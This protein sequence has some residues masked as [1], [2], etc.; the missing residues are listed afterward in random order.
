MDTWCDDIL[1]EIDLVSTLGFPGRIIV[2]GKQACPILTGQNEDDVIMA[3]CELGKGR[4][5]VFAHSGYGNQLSDLNGSFENSALYRNVRNWLTRKELS[6]KANILNLD[7]CQNVK[8]AK[9]LETYDLLMST[10]IKES[11]TCQMVEEYIKK[12]GAFVHAATPWGYMQFNPGKKPYEMAYMNI[13][14]EVGISY[15]KELSK[16]HGPGYA[17]ELSKA[18]DA[19]LSRY[20]SEEIGKLTDKVDLFRQLKEL[21][22]KYSS[23]FRQMID[24]HWKVLTDNVTRI[25]SSGQIKSN[26]AK[27]KK[28]LDFWLLAVD[29]L[30]KKNFKAPGVK[31]FPGDF[32][33]LPDLTKKDVKFSSTFEDF[34][35]TSCYVPAGTEANVTVS[36]VTNRWTVI[37]G[38]HS[39]C[40]NMER[41][42]RWPKITIETE[43]DKAGRYDISSPFGGSV[44]F[45]SPKQNSSYIEASINDIVT[46]PRFDLVTKGKPWKESRNDSGL[47][48]DISGKYVTVTLPSSSIRNVDDPT[49]IMELYDHLLK[50]YHDLRG[51]NIDKERK[52]WIV[53]DIQ[54]THYMHAG[55]PIVTHLDVADPSKVCFLLNGKSFKSADFWGIYHEIGHNMQQSE[56]TFDGTLEVTVNI[57][58]LYGMYVICGIDP[59]THSWLMRQTKGALHYLKT[60]ADFSKWK[61]EAGMALYTYAQLIHSFKWDAYKRVFRRYQVLNPS[62]KPKSDQDKI[63]L[64]FLI[65][66][67]ETKLNLA[68][69]GIF[70]G[71]PF[72]EG[73]LKK[74]AALNFKP[75]LPEDE[76]TKEVPDRVKFVKSRFPALVQK[77]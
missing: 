53:T 52:M 22:P 65:F 68:P 10:G 72:S 37:V 21:P 58:T 49:Q 70:W 4:I 48:A 30:G 59:W 39:D 45:L 2:F 43:I 36:K 6:N 38:A 19:N 46:C 23:P 44:Y 71:L 67:E 11:V 14:L 54:T 75:F 76:I 63:D 42:N 69:V 7:S 77:V 47:W 34:H 40:L 17:P 61:G 31:N 3:A 25:M 24:K 50:T 66:S 16:S 73:G 32:D 64:W 56:W 35:F 20:A 12:G 18:S 29:F 60:G 1:F 5:V 13:L 8:N 57:F 55:Y 28:L 27:E 33:S 62:E 41:V 26:N 74:I 51:T 15:S 9:E